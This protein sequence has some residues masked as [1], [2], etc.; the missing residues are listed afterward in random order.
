MILI[1]L[2]LDVI[3]WVFRWN[4]EPP[5]VYDHKIEKEEVK[6]GKI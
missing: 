4:D 3:A 1:A 5:K 6:N 2:V